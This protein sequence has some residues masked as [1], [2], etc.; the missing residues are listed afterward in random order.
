MMETKMAQTQIVFTR[1]DDHTDVKVAT[2][3]R[4]REFNGWGRARRNPTDPQMPEI[5]EELALARALE[6][7]TDQLR[8]VACEKTIAAREGHSILLHL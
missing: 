3:V 6:D 8:D 4:G 1:D 7:L 5:G 2:H